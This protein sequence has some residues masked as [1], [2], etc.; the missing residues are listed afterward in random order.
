M[1][2]VEENEINKRKILIVDDEDDITLSFKRILEI[3]GFIVDTFNDS[4]VAL[5]EFKKK[6]YDLALIDIKMPNLDGFDLY[7]QLKEL[8]PNLKIFF[9]TASEAYYEQYR[10]K[11]YSKLDR[12]LFIQKPIELKAL[13][14]KIN[15]SLD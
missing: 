13:L 2:D 6:Y 4:T 15:H 10:K 7:K 12:G 5:S 11:D 1:L 14:E 9:L 8:D 3:Y